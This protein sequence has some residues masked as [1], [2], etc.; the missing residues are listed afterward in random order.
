MNHRDLILSAPRKAKHQFLA[1]PEE[2]QDRIVDGLDAGTMT[3]QG[4][5][6]EIKA[7]GHSLS[8]EAV[9]NY[10]RAVRRERRRAQIQDTLAGVLETVKDRDEQALVKAAVNLAL[11][12]IIQGLADGEIGFRDLD[13]TRLLAANPREAAVVE[14]GEEP[15]EAADKPLNGAVMEKLRKGLSPE[16]TEQLKRDFLGVK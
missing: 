11:A 9:S 15:R 13:T 8:H 2:L 7:A 4:A 14:T 3:L 12:N 6:D 16:E 5:S 1:L 10:Y